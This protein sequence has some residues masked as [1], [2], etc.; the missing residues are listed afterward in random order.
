[1]DENFQSSDHRPNYS[2]FDIIAFKENQE[3]KDIIEEEI[4]NN[5]KLGINNK[6]MKRKNLSY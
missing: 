2:I 6:Y 1:M 4:I 3:R 5:E